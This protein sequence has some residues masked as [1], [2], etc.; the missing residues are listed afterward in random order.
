MSMGGNIVDELE[1]FLEH[2]KYDVD[3]HDDELF[4]S[5]NIDDLINYI[6]KRKD[7]LLYGPPGTGKTFLLDKLKSVLSEEIGIKYNIQFHS[8][9]SYEDFVE[10]II[11]NVENQGFKYSDGHLLNFFKQIDEYEK[12]NSSENKIHLLLIDE[13]NR[14]DITSVFGETM[15]IIEN[16][17]ERVIYTSKTKQ[18]VSFPKN[19]VIIGAMNT[20]DRTLSKM[21]LALRRRFKF[22]PIY[23]SSEILFSLLSTYGFSEEVPFTVQQYVDVFKDINFKISRNPIYGKDMTLGHIIWVPELN[24]T[25]SITLTQIS[26]TFRKIIFPQIESFTRSDTEFIKKIFGVKICNL[27][28]YG[29][30]ISDE[31]IVEM[32]TAVENDQTG[33]LNES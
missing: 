9:Y 13:I 23:P 8:T 33:V 16:K 19:A 31:A 29:E 6:K 10:G 11:P 1:E 32:I 12:Q 26:E 30:R 25:H 22:L 27:L 5:S 24:E 21:D 7:V 17:G 28:A 20:S 4:Y 14:A 2:A 18:K 3:H 15:N